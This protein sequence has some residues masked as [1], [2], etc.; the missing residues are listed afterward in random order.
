MV[1]R[2]WLTGIAAPSLG[3]LVEQSRNWPLHLALVNL[4]NFGVLGDDVKCPYP[5]CLVE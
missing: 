1:P 4:A 2:W 3:E 5:Y